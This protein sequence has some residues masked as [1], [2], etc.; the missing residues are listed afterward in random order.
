MGGLL[1]A[2]LV[3]YWPALRAGWIW[4]D[5]SYVTANAL[6]QSPEGL[7][8][9]W[10]PGQTP[11]Y[12]PLV[13]LSFW[14]QYALHGLNPFWFH[15]VNVL[16][17]GC[18]TVLLWRILVRLGVPGALLA[19]ALFALHPVQVESVAWVTERKNVLSMALALVSV[20]AWLRWRDGT[21]ART[22]RT[23]CALSLAAFVGAMLAKTT[24]VAVPVA[25]LAIDWWRGRGVRPAAVVMLG[26]MTL[27][28]V[29]MGLHT[30]HVEVTHVGACGVMF[31]R[32]FVERLAQAAQAWWFYPGS[33]ARPGG[34]M[35]V[36]PFFA[37][38]P[39]GWLPWLALAGGVAV[40]LFAVAAARRGRRGPLALLAI[41]ATGIFPA[42]GFINVYP[43]RFAPVADHF[44]YVAGVAIC[45]A[46]GWSMQ[47]LWRLVCEREFGGANAS[48][49][50]PAMARKLALGKGLVLLFLG[51]LGLET[52]S[53]AC[54]YRDERF[55]WECALERNP[56][57]WLASSNLAAMELRAF[58]VAQARAD[59]AA[60]EQHL[61]QAE[62][63]A[64][65]AVQDAAGTDLAALNNLAEVRRQQGRL[66]EALQLADQAV[67]VHPEAPLARW[68]RG[69]LREFCGLTEEAGE[70][71]AAA[72]AAELHA[73]YQRD[74]MRW[75]VQRGRMAEA[76]Q[77]AE[78]LVARHPL[79]PLALADLGSLQLETGDPVA[80]RISFARAAAL[81]DELLHARMLLRMI[82]ADLRPPITPD[83]VARGRAMAQTLVQA[84]P[85]EPIPLLLL[86]R[87][88]A[89]QGE[90]GAATQLLHRAEELLQQMPEEARRAAEPYRARAA[91][92]VEGARVDSPM[93]H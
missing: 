2:L 78:R 91:E 15:L 49:S 85:E 54:T 37:Q 44:G 90:H 27:I 6:V 66:A 22:A 8:R 24:A 11:Q 87:A 42:L 28:G 74:W 53:A 46:A 61:R 60:M 84:A 71:Y 56:H 75:L 21:N 67:A 76:R 32:T 77:V 26:V 25:L 39:E 20:L 70:D 40:L 52:W 50:E 16:L 88:Q 68:Q 36:Y 41:Y 80:A 7:W 58:D 45:V 43:L 82:D 4:D 65:R 29:G 9:A 72:A 31:E 86:A 5:D 89:L 13:F 23:W 19:A 35:F 38:G 18:S 55:L 69:R 59:T 3:A 12:Y 81:G 64:E 51:W 1:L 10:I 83:L 48:D 17:H 93:E 30:A 33:W 62:H 47:T 57:A 79:D 92:A 34:V 73:D 14:A 63:Y